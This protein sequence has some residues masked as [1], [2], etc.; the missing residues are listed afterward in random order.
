MILWFIKLA[1]SKIKQRFY[2]DQNVLGFWRY[3]H[4]QI[5]V[6]HIIHI[7]EVTPKPMPM[8]GKGIFETTCKVIF[9]DKDGYK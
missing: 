8:P 2:P 7:S 3:W 5:I 4:P 9:D 1:V 6:S